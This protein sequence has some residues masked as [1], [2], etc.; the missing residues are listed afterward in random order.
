V[1]QLGALNGAAAPTDAL[2]RYLEASRFQ[3]EALEQQAAAA[4]YARYLRAAV[5]RLS[6]ALHAAWRAQGRAFLQR[7]AAHRSAFAEAPGEGAWSGAWD[8]AARETDGLF[9]RALTDEVAGAYTGGL[10]ASVVVAGDP[11]LQAEIRAALSLENPRAVA[12]LQQHAAARVVGIQ[13]TTRDGIRKIMV[14]AAEEGWSY[15]RAQ[16][17]IRQHFAGFGGPSPLGHIANRAELVAVTEL[18]EGYGQA[19]R[20]VGRYLAR[21]GV[22]MEKA[23]LTAEDERVCPECEAN[24]ADDWI[25]LE[26]GFS[27]SGA[28]R[29]PEHPGCRCAVVYR[30]AR[31]EEP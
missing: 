19:Q 3:V 30:R 6:K 12:W 10:A 16:R 29:E 8:D 24:A 28:L 13:N 27:A 20:E 2:V 9:L 14:Q 31:E 18:A 7:L 21:A 17:E 26:A 23:W 15:A 22:E 25:E 11:V 4:A 5:P 1:G